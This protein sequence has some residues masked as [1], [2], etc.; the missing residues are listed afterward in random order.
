MSVTNLAP[1]LEQRLTSAQKHLLDLAADSSQRHGVQLFLVGGTVRDMLMGRGMVD[2]DLSL[3]GGTP[4]SVSGVAGELGGEVI[5]H[6][7]F[8]TARVQVGDILVDLAMARKESYAHPGALPAV[9]PGTIGEDLARRDFTVNAMA[10]SLA[11][12]SRGDLIDPLDGRGD[13]QRGLIKVLHPRS[14][15]DD[16]T[17][18]LRAI[19][20]RQRLQFQ[21]ECETERLIRQN[22]SFL[23]TISGERIRHELQRILQE[24]QAASMLALA[25]ELAILPA[26]YL[27]LALDD[28][29][30][31]R[32]QEVQVE[33]TIDNDLLFLTALASSIPTEKLPGFADRL[34]MD[35]R[36][37]KVVKDVG[38]IQDARAAL[39]TPDLKRSRLHNVL[40]HLDPAAVKGYA[41]VTRE[42]VV[43]GNLQLYARELRYEKPL[44]NGDDLIELGVPQGPMVGEL[45]DGIFSARLDGFVATREDEV[46][47]ILS[48]VS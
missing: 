33:P 11:P 17:R 1:F 4:L 22:L 12:G 41:L 39:M 23:D 9:S 18:I 16:G 27:P 46:D 42:A 15:E 28:F 47:F 38:S 32:L 48:R 29:A 13:I 21:F 10:I 45:L 24:D 5:A 36:W 19:R 7:Q 2:L 25:Q 44:L 3:V 8:G 35:A 6:S 31:G 20:Y 34:N 43:V 26:I 40:R 30:L 37:A 14:F